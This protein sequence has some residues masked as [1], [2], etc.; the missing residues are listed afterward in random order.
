[1]KPNGVK[2]FPAGPLTSRGDVGGSVASLRLV[3]N[4]SPIYRGNIGI[5][6]APIFDIYC[7]GAARLYTTTLEM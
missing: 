7:I 6:V 2:F 5:S 3:A 4:I 1:M